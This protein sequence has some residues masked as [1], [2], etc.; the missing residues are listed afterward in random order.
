MSGLADC[1]VT[2]SDGKGD[3]SKWRLNYITGRLS[4]GNTGN[5][6]EWDRNTAAE[7]AA[8]GW[9]VQHLVKKPPYQHLDGSQ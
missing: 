7:L 3:S 4:D 9:G 5:L 8:E 6:G 2:V 1:L